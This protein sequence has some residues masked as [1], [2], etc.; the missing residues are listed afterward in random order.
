MNNNTVDDRSPGERV[1]VPLTMDIRAALKLRRL[2]IA[3]A[4]IAHLRQLLEEVQ[5]NIPECFALLVR[6]KLGTNSNRNV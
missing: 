3:A 4:Y 1:C 5:T 6:R 2:R